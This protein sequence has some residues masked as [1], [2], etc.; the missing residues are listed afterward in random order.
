MYQLS[1]QAGYKKPNFSV[2][3]DDLSFNKGQI[4]GVI[5]DN[6]SGKSTIFKTL[7]GEIKPLE[8]VIPCEIIKNC[9]IVSEHLGIPVD[10]KVC[11]LMDLLDPVKYS[12][13][14]SQYDEI[15]SR[16]F[17]FNE[18]MIKDLSSGQRRILQIFVLLAS[19]KKYM[20]FDEACTY[21]DQKNKDQVLEAIKYVSNNGIIVIYT[22]HDMNDYVV[23]ESCNYII[24]NNVLIREN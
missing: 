21:L 18:K 22:S 7:I 14:Q 23:L 17:P 11:H 15:Y 8:G 6:G 3:V 1:F 24:K 5:G 9:S 16:I 13:A 12:K 20:I 2:V 10:C 4:V 19:E